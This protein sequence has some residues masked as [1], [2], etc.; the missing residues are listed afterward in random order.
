MR[1]KTFHNF[2]SAIGLIL[3]FVYAV[4]SEW[5]FVEGAHVAK[6]P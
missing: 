2:M 4:A 1:D 3:E 5:S 6:F